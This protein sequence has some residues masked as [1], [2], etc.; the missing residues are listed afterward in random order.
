MWQHFS[1]SQWQFLTTPGSFWQHLPIV[2]PLQAPD[3]Y[4]TTTWLQKYLLYILQ[5][6]RKTAT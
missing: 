5:Y 2:G 3:Q 4:Y 6:F 1:L